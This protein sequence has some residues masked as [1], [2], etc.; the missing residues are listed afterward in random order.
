MPEVPGAVPVYSTGRQIADVLLE[1]QVQGSEV[2]TQP[3]PAGRRGVVTNCLSD[4]GRCARASYRS[5]AGL[6]G[7]FISWEMFIDTIRE[8][9]IFAS[10]EPDLCCDWSVRHSELCL[11]TALIHFLNLDAWIL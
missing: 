6:P 9:L 7:K 5:T 11:I 8:I 3:R 10:Q 4:V 1:A 2:H